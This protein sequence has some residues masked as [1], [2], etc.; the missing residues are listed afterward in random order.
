LVEDRGSL[1]PRKQAD[2]VD[3]RKRLSFSQLDFSGGQANVVG[4]MNPP[5][6]P[7]N[8]LLAR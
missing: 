1:A 2:L 4:P 3:P 7:V 8:P 6:G 5:F